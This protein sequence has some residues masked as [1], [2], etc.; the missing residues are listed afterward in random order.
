MVNMYDEDISRVQ[1]V[2][3]LNNT[4]YADLV[5]TTMDFE[6]HLQGAPE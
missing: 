4:V 2:Y 1:P 3:P 5:C 6:P